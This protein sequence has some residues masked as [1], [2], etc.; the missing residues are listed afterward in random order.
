MIFDLDGT[1]LNTLEDLAAAGNH[2]CETHGWPTFAVDEYR[3]KVGNGM[4]KLVERFMPAEYAGDS[5]MFEQ[6]LAEF[7]AYY[8]EHKEDHTA[9]YAGTIEMLDRL[10]AAGV[11]LAV[12]TNKDHVSAAPL[13]EKYFGSERF[14]LVQGRVDAFPPKPEAPVTLHV[15][16]ELGANPA[17]TLYVG[18]SNVDILTGHNAGLKSAGV[19]WGFRGR[20]ELEAAGATTWWTPRQSSRRWHWASSE[21]RRAVAAFG[22][23]PQRTTRNPLAHHRIH[24]LGGCGIVGRPLVILVGGI[25]KGDLGVLGLSGLGH[26]DHDLAGHLVQVI[27]GRHRIECGDLLL[28]LGGEIF[29]DLIHGLAGDGNL[30]GRSAL[31]LIDRHIADLVIKALEIA[32]GVLLGIDAQLLKLVARSLFQTGEEI[33]AAVLISSNWLVR[34]LVMSSSTEGPPQ[35]E[36]KTTHAT[37]AAIRAQAAASFHDIPPN[38]RRRVPCAAHVVTASPY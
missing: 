25:F 38:K 20:A 6:T 7:R 19:S 15:M 12:L 1:I 24:H 4:L 29:D 17:T 9:P 34:S 32:L 31:V 16:E 37:R 13:I 23:T 11:Q 26:V 30:G 28:I 22:K 8:G 36:S 33:I 2:T 10:R 3:Y 21:R 27:L 35:P 18:D 5:R 14:A